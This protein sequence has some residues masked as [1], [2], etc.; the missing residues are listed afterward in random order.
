MIG[1]ILISSALIVSLMFI[2]S[3]IE[4]S[5]STIK[6]AKQ[7]Q[8]HYLLVKE[9]KTLIAKNYNINPE[10][11]TRDDIIAHLPKGENWEKI[12]LLDRQKDS[13]LS[14][15]EFVNSDANIFISE[16]ET[17]KLL[18]LKAKLKSSFDNEN[19][20]KDSSTGKIEFP[21]ALEEKAHFRQDLDFDKRVDNAILYLTNEILYN[22]TN[23]NI[24]N[25]VVLKYN[26]SS[27][28]IDNGFFDF[29]LKYTDKE[30][31]N[32]TH[33]IDAIRKAIKEK[34]EKSDNSQKV[35][36]YDKLKNSL[37]K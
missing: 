25:N 35:Q 8:E 22:S 36:L 19:L 31:E 15:K 1:K 28:N 24:L 37:G 20:I 16:D 17:I 23:I 12:L 5:K 30:D 29:S 7:I 14:N 32:Y 4:S 2:A 18:A 27:P 26:E 10:N 13:N 11:I 3:Q 33:K 9:I 21:I 34:L 6:E